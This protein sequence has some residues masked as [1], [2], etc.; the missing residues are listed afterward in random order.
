M[1][2]GQYVVGD[3]SYVNSLT[4]NAT[5]GYQRV[6]TAYSRAFL[7]QFLE[8]SPSRHRGSSETLIPGVPGIHVRPIGLVGP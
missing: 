2:L 3:A 7:G 4:C 5:G 8:E 6:D 1:F